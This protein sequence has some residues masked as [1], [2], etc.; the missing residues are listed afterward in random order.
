MVSALSR[1]TCSTSSTSVFPVVVATAAGMAV[2]GEA[3]G[4]NL[5][6]AVVGEPLG[7]IT[8]RGKLFLLD[9]G[10]ELT[11]V[12]HLMSAGRLQLW[13]KRAGLRDKTSR[14]LLRAA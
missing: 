7:P 10:E 11:M 8:R 4:Q 1:T 12:I 5:V 9:V 6:Q 2:A 3:G 13:E 14:L